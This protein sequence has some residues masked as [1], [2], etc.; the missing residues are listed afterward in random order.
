MSCLKASSLGQELIAYAVVSED[1]E[2][3]AEVIADLTL[4]TA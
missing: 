2:S 3:L 4:D 1:E